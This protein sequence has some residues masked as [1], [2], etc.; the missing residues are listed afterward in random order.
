MS[1]WY[2]VLLKIKQFLDQ[3]KLGEGKNALKPKA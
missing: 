2:P 3:A 1:S